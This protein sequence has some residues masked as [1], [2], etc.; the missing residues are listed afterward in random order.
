MPA[1][2]FPVCVIDN[3]YEHPHDI[4]NFAL[5]QTYYPNEDGR[6]PGSRSKH[7][8]DLDSHLYHYF[9]RKILSV[10]YRQFEILD[11]HVETTFQKIKP[12]NE[13]KDHPIN[14]GFIHQDHVL[15][16]G[17]V[18]LDLE[19][20]EHTGTSIYTPRKKWLTKDLLSH[21]VNKFKMKKYKGGEITEDEINLWDL[22]RSKYIESVRV[23]NIF[24]RCILFDGNTNHGVPFF[25]SKERLTQVFFVHNIQFSSHNIETCY[26]LAP[27][28]ST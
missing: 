26:P 14:R 6:W 9:V 11:Y 2:L 12:F 17:V 15:F 13:K 8:N 27:R 23:E 25:G 3:F 21:D 1:E 20:E 19:Y 7:I 28:T 4:R 24:N 5:E 16:G 22:D 10:F 18:Y